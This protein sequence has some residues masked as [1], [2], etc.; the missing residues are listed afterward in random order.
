M[1]LSLFLHYLLHQQLHL[2]LLFQVMVFRACDQ[3]E[4]K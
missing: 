1:V 4:H 2:V 3:H